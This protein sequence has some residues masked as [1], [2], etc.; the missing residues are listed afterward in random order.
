MVACSLM[1]ILERAVTAVMIGIDPHKS[2]HKAV[3]ISA[4]EEPLAKAAGPAPAAQGLTSWSGGRRPGRNGPGAVEGA[5]VRG[6]LLAQHLVTAGERVLDVPPELAARARLL[7]AGDTNENDPNDALSV[8][9]AAL[10]SRTR[11]PVMAEDHAAVLKVWAKRHRDLARSR[12]QVGSRLAPRGT[13]PG[14]LRC[15]QRHQ[16]GHRSSRRPHSGGRC[17]R[18]APAEI[19]ALASWPHD[20][21]E[22]LRRLDEQMPRGEEEAR[23]RGTALG[24]RR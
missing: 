21:L 15:R 3:A 19:G 10:R 14:D 17:G 16:G 8:A 7:Q 4:A 12:N 1:T 22:D 6:H 23:G 13:P 24:H 2:S 5:S 18:P 11:R 9:V 20:L